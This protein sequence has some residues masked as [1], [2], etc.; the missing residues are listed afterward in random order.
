MAHPDLHPAA[1]AADL[2]RAARFLTR[3]PIPA[4]RDAPPAGSLARALRLFPL[5]GA[6]LGAAA[7][8]VLAVAAWIGL[9]PLAAALLAIGVVALATGGL[10]QDGLADTAD[11]LGGGRDREHAL[12]IM[13][14]SRIGSFG[15]LALILVVGLE[16]AA[17]AAMAPAAAVAALVAA[18]AGSRAAI[19]VAARL[20]D[21]ARADGLGAAMGRPDP[22]AVAVAVALATLAAIVPLGPSAGIAALAAAALATAALGWL[23]RRRIGGYTGDVLGAIQQ[24]TEMTIL[25]AAAAAA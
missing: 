9:P 13:R 5:V 24:M 11:G 8:L 16:A 25:L 17:I 3:L 18:G 7:G 10:H 15:T 23:A 22:P 12:A 2:G 19:A 14:D 6:G 20:L 4:E 21:P 1:W